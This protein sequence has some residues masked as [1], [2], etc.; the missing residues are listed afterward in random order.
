MNPFHYAAVVG[1]NRYPGISHLEGPVNDANDFHDWLVDMG[2]V[3]EEN[4]KLLLTSQTMPPDIDVADARPIKVQIDDM[5]EDLHQ[6][7]ARDTAPD[8]DRRWDKSRLYVFLAGHGIMPRGGVSALLM[9]NARKDRYE[10]FE[11]SKYIEWYSENGGM[12]KEVVFFADCCRN[13]YG[14]V[15]PS[16]VPFSSSAT[17]PPA[18]VFSLAG[19][20]SAPGNPAYEEK[21]AAIPPQERRGYFTKALLRGLRDAARVDPTVG[22]ITGATLAPYVKT[23]VAEMTRRKRVPQEIK[24]PSSDLAYTICFG[25]PNDVLTSDVRILFPPSFTREV[26]LLHPDGTR[27][28]FADAPKPWVLKLRDGLYSVV[29]SESGEGTSFADDGVFVVVG[30]RD[31]QL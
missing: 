19:Y 2:G 16:R 28:T 29:S 10:N 22:A 24:M 3:P 21:E 23:A 27:E 8:F 25:S 7:V 26:D 9:A 18:T 12:F 13:W 31:V 11:V 1:I 17:G 30:E 14:R 20:A 6:Q 4:V 5:L 15:E